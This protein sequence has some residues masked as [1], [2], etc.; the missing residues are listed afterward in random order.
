VSNK[1][2]LLIID[3]HA[4]VFR[5]YY[6][7]FTTGMKTKDGVPSWAVYGFTKAVFDTIKSY[8]P[9]YLI[10]TF[11]TGEPTFRHHLYDLYKANR[12]KAPD[13]FV[14][15]MP[16]IN[17][18][19]EALEIPVFQMV[20]FEADDLIG[21]LSRQASEKGIEVGII[22]GDQDL[23]QLTDDEN[24]SVFLPQKGSDIKRFGKAEVIEKYGV[25]PKQFIDFKAIKGDSSDNIPGISGIGE[26]GALKL[27]LE[28]DSLENIY[29]NIDKMKANKQRE[30]LINDKENA[31]LFQKLVT[32]ERFVPIEIDLEKCKTQIHDKSNIERV[33][34]K[35]NFRTMVS[36]LPKLFSSLKHEQSNLEKNS[37]EDEGDDLWFDFNDQEHGQAK[38][39]LNLKI[40]KN[41]DELKSL[42][43]D[44]NSLPYFS[45]DLETTGLISLN[46]EIVGI[47][48]SHDKNVEE[49]KAAKFNTFYI[50]LQHIDS[51][52]LDIDETIKILKPVLENEKVLKI[53]HNLKYEINVF[54]LYGINLNGIKDDTY[55]ASYVLNPSSNHGLKDLAKSCFHYFM[56]EISEL[57][58]KGKTQ[59]TMKEVT[60]EKA[61]DYAGADA[62]VTLELSFF[63]REKMK[64]S[65]ENITKLYE[66]IEL[67][68]VK[69]LADMEEAGIKVDQKHLDD[70]SK[71]LT[72]LAANIEARVYVLAGKTFNINSP[73][74]MSQVLFD[75]LKISPKG[76]KKNKNSSYSTDAGVLEKLAGEY[77]IVNH[78]LEYRQI[79]KI[80]STYA[81][82]LSSIIN[83]KT[84]KIHTS[85]NQAITTTGRLSSSDPNLQNIPIK[86]E[87]GKEIRKAF[88]ISDENHIL[89]TAD[90]SQIELRLL[91]HYTQ[92]PAFL[93][94]FN[95]NKDIHAKTI[96]DI[97]GIDLSLVTPDMRRIGKT[98]NFGII[99]GQTAYGL[100]EGLKIP[101]REAS[102]IIKK[103]NE[104]Y[105]SIVKYTEEMVHFAEEHGYVKTL[106]G[107]QRYIPDIGSTNRAMREF[108]KRTA[109][110]TP[111]QGTAADLIKIAMIKVDKALKDAGL[112]TKMLLQVHDELVFEAPIEEKEIATNLIKNV[113]ES[114]S[115]EI[116]V[117]LDV[118]VHDG[119]S[120]IEAK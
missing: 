73:K 48:I 79:M 91:A 105:T 56:T 49:K 4:L 35:L 40:I 104:K 106:F 75:D 60:A 9:D 80:K 74:Q 111:L 81:D 70:L 108:A 63:L 32:I 7:L 61:A 27:L 44:L 87:L 95:N 86:S 113:M 98:V 6:A 51:E 16:F 3:G 116:T 92:D 42:V 119:N 58:G 5:S 43:D 102:E 39:E 53:G 10:V 36:T 118:S 99:Y 67:P 107:R 25:T 34:N 66:E 19:V 37:S 114:V 8:Q 2:H 96:S 115:P 109:I 12:A 110:N 41:I 31:F 103:F 20:G 46:T 13:D 52:N 82:S 54:S 100:S 33:L 112:K 117:P 47:S 93:D 97:L 101:V 76:V 72:D 23:L 84:G 28:Y 50:P 15:Q 14:I 62:A 65:E 24:I 18:I 78:I 64:Y 90:Y 71:R 120:W 69:V 45:I 30:Y 29:N 17:E 85:F 1:K 94:A 21:T 89:I 88:V 38:L 22:T 83:S 55:I 57:I 77:E 68:L 26:K 11:D 59:I